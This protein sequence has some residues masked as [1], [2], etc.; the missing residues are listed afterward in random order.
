MKKLVPVVLAMFV[1][2]G[3]SGVALASDKPA[4]PKVMEACKGAV[5]KDTKLSPEDAKKAIEKCVKD[6]GP[7]DKK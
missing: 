7:K 3:F 1:G 5:A 6:G 4:D 2:V